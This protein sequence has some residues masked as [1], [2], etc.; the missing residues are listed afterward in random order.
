[1]MGSFTV[2]T[3]RHVCLFLTL[4]MWGPRSLMH[5]QLSAISD[6]DIVFMHR[7][8]EANRKARLSDD[9]SFN[10]KRHYFL[11]GENDRCVPSLKH[12][13]SFSCSQGCLSCFLVC[14]QVKL[15]A[16]SPSR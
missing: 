10:W 8:A 6:G 7:Q 1:M 2:L 16:C 5:L 11:P 9:G 4:W 12:T 15:F 3:V 13:P 14:A